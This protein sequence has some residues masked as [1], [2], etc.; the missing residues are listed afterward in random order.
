MTNEQKQLIREKISEILVKWE[1]PTRQIAIN[2]IV[3]EFDLA[4]KQTEE[5]IVKEMLQTIEDYR[6]FPDEVHCTCLEAFKEKHLEEKCGCGSPESHQLY[7]ENKC[8]V[9]V[10]TLIR[11]K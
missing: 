11:N 10:I 1:M 9:K 6:C 8:P 5:R 4:I 3:E 7:K 2:E